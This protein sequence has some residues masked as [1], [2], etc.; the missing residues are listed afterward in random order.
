MSSWV[1]FNRDFG[2]GNSKGFCRGDIY[3]ARA[4]SM[5]RTPTNNE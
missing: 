3:D 2:T 4:G 1:E 5:N